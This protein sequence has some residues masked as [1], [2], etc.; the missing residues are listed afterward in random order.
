MLYQPHGLNERRAV[1]VGVPVVL[2]LPEAAELPLHQSLLVHHPLLV[3]AVTDLHPGD[4]VAAI[5]IPLLLPILMFDMRF[6]LPL[7]VI[8]RYHLDLAVGAPLPRTL[9][10][11]GL[12]E[13]EG[14]AH[15][16][17]KCR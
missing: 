16:P 17:V 5:P 10:L 4:G 13:G 8:L 6:H 12:C 7:L 2:L 11:G 14:P 9:G 1:L 15:L 3:L